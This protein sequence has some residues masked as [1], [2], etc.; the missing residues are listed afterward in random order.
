MN[1]KPTMPTKYPPFGVVLKY[2][3][4]QIPGTI[5]LAIIL[6]W[7]RKWFNL[8]DYLVWIAVLIW[9]GKDVVLFPYLWRSYDSKQIPDRF[10]MIGRQGIALSDLTPEGYV[11]IN[12]ERWKAVIAD[13]DVFVANGD[14]IYVKVVNGLQLTVE[15]CLKSSET[16]EK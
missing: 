13:A 4:L 2:I 15:P 8:P 16:S 11:Q 9:V 7:A 14:K 6:W 12:G 10:E 5:V 1:M 3:L